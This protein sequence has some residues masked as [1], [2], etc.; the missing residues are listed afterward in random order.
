MGL[1]FKQVIQNRKMK[2]KWGFEKN[3][4]RGSF[5]YGKHINKENEEWRECWN[6]E[7]GDEKV[8]EYL[9]EIGIQIY[10]TKKGSLCQFFRNLHNKVIVSMS[11]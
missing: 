3:R 5:L 6:G 7:K 1:G 9:L 11:S 4:E 2:L 8:R 10:E